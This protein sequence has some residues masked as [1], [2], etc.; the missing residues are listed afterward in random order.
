[1]IRNTILLAGPTASGKSALALRLAEQ[2]NGIVINADSMQVYDVLRILTARPG[3]EDLQRADHRLYGHVSPASVYSTGEY[4]RE[5]EQLGQE[6]EGRRLIFV[7]GTGLYFRSLIEGLSTMPDIPADIR[8]HWRD[9]LLKRGPEELHGELARRDPAMAEI[10]KSGDSQRIVRAMEVIAAS[11]ISILD[12][13]KIKNTPLIDVHSAKMCVLVSERGQLIERISRRFDTMVRV[14]ALEEVSAL[15]DMEL[16]PAV[17]AMKAIG[18]RE[19]GEALAGQRD[20]DEAINLAKIA[21]RQY[22]RRQTTWFRNQFGPDWRRLDVTSESDLK[23]FI[24]GV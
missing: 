21:T 17:P 24:S 9:Q 22:S 3:D 12:W 4:L 8:N 2:C 1:M 11:G 16:D 6:L 20:M 18:V 10:L 7:G 5:V 19:L 13:Q 14:G 23:D 15:L